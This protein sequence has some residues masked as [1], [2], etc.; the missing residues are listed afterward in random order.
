MPFEP[1]RA[2]QAAARAYYM[3]PEELIAEAESI[4]KDVIDAM[5]AAWKAEDEKEKNPE[6]ESENEPEEEGD[7]WEYDESK[8]TDYQRISF[9]LEPVIEG[10]KY[11]CGQKIAEL[12]EKRKS[13]RRDEEIKKWDEA[14]EAWYGIPIT[15]I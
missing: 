2:Q 4:A 10:V 5:H 15:H 8:L 3:T 13:P 1:N 9:S 6:P 14:Y 7:D 11:V 12:E